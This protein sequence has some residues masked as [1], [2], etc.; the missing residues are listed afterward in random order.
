MKKR[1]ALL[2]LLCLIFGLLSGCRTPAQQLN[3]LECS[4]MGDYT[5]TQ[6]SIPPSVLDTL[7]LMLENYVSGIKKPDPSTL[8][9]TIADP[10]DPSDPTNPSDSTDPSSSTTPL[11]PTDSTTTPQDREAECATVEEMKAVIL[12]AMTE[13]VDYVFFK[14]N[15]SVFSS[16]VLYDV[17]FEQLRDEYMVETLGMQSYRATYWN[18]PSGMVR[19]KLDMIWLDDE[20]TLEQV[21]EMKNQTLTKAKEVIRQLD[22]ANKN[23]YEK[24]FAVNQ[25]LCDNCVYPDAEPYTNISHTPYGALI[26]KS[27]V[28]EGYA[29]AA[30]LI[31]SL[32][33]MDSF[34]VVGE[35][36]GGG[37][38]WNLVKV[39]G[40][41]YQLD[42]TWNDADYQPNL[43]FLVTDSYMSL[44]RTWDRQRY[45][46]TATTPYKP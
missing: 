35:T 13:T 11:D 27:A 32:C 39:D 21:K 37:H 3:N 22:L 5:G 44:S 30:Q 19:V 9:V 4:V 24:V 15:S 45:P 38:A 23:D 31:L 18:L 7:E 16:Q 1:V 12:Q 33:G 29:R 28:C 17:V 40:A 14:V 10:T 46:A 42:C 2:L 20:Y 43:Y 36:S 34:Y 25:Y 8:Q 6:E 26:E 41:Y